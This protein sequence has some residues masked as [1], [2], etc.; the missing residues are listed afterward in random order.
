[1][2]GAPGGAGDVPPLRAATGLLRD[3]RLRPA[4]EDVPRP[5]RPA[6]LPRRRRVRLDR[7]DH[8]NVNNTLVPIHHSYIHIYLYTG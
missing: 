3:P 2:R 6:R 5:V 4:A 7:Q 1:M 8:G